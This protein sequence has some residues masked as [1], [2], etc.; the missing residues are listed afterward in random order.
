[1]TEDI[2]HQLVNGLQDSPDG[3]ERTIPFET[4]VSP[5]GQPVGGEP[6][7]MTPDA[8]ALSHSLSLGDASQSEAEGVKG[9]P[10]TLGDVRALVQEELDQSRE[11][12]PRLVQAELARER[13]D[14]RRASLSALQQAADGI[15]E[16]KVEFLA[17]ELGVLDEEERCA[18]RDADAPLR[19]RMALVDFIR[20]RRAMVEGQIAEVEA[21]LA[22][23][24]TET[25]LALAEL[26]GHGLVASLR[27]ELE[28]QTQAIATVET[29]MAE[30]PQA[31][32]GGLGLVP[33]L[34]ALALVAVLGVAGI[35]LPRHR[36][37]SQT[38][39]GSGSRILIELATLNQATG[40]TEAAIELLNEALEAG[41]GD[42][43]TLG[44]VGQTY[45]ALKE[46]DKALEV[47]ARAVEKAPKNQEYRLA[48]ARSYSKVGQCQEAIAHYEKLIDADPG[49]WRYYL[50][51]G[52]QY[53]VLGD[54]DLALVQYQK[55]VEVVPDRV[56]GY[57]SQGNLYRDLERYNAAIPAYKRALEIN[58]NMSWVRVFLGQSYVA[59]QD[60]ERAV[61]QFRAAIEL[62]P[63]NPEPYLELGKVWRAQGEY[64][65]ALSW[66]RDALDVQPD[67]VPTFLEMGDTYLELEDCERATLWFLRV[68]EVWPNNKVAQDGL[69]A[70]QGE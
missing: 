70:C 54:H 21:A 52:E 48:L 23:R 9:L 38:Q 35:L 17:T 7:E 2:V 28:R 47:L 63:D 44:Q 12:V 10:F 22:R 31:K 25:D 16:L 13:Q 5:A 56:E 55:V 57:T 61:E 64:E 29:R 40:E 60:W 67:H 33:R 43:E 41:I 50:E 27:G 34:L 18:L 11:D 20:E 37:A 36:E 49:N 46:Y 1:M 19:D 24:V 62:A 32:P 66:Y 4:A 42:V 6:E 26:E 65:Q 30:L 14:R 68:L 3:K 51:M 53:E 69:R 8:L 15:S 59:L 39:A 45:Y 58:P